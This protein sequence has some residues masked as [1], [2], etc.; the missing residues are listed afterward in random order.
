MRPGGAHVDARLIV[1][2]LVPNIKIL[3]LDRVIEAADGLTIMEAA[4]EHGL[5]WPTTCGGEGICPSFACP[6]DE[7]EANPQPPWRGEL[8]KLAAGLGEAAVRAP[9]PRLA[10]PR[11]G[12]RGL[13]G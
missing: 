2:D 7:G 1:G 12:H 6:I 4:H 13:N 10:R 3:P 9:G 11:R 8:K 5:Y